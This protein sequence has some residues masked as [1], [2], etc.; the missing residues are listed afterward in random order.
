ML[1]IVLLNFLLVFSVHADKSCYK[2]S[3]CKNGMYCAPIKGEFPG[4]CAEK[5][6]DVSVKKK[7]CMKNSDCPKD[8]ICA[9]IKGEYPGGCAEGMH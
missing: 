3:D 7:G 9:T 1:K 8:W 5:M 4:G 2:N 6:K